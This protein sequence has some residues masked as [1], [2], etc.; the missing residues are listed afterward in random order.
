MYAA[1][2]GVSV[3]VGLVTVGLNYRAHRINRP[4]LI[5]LLAMRN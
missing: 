4:N 3:L 1:T 2:L 5:V